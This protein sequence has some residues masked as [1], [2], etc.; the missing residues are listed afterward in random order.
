MASLASVFLLKETL[1]SK[2]AN[3]H[4][5]LTQD[6]EQG[7]KVSSNSPAADKGNAHSVHTCFLPCQASSRKLPAAVNACR[8]MSLMPNQQQGSKPLAQCI[9]PT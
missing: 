8:N 5:H 3:T 4:S 9:A 6:V 2:L 1:P 7:M